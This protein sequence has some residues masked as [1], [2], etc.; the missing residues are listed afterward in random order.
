[1]QSC[2]VILLYYYFIARRSRSD[3][4]VVRFTF[5]NFHRL[6][7]DQS[8]FCSYRGHF[9]QCVFKNRKQWPRVIFLHGESCREPL[10]SLRW[11][12]IMVNQE[13]QCLSLCKNN[14]KG[15]AASQSSLSIWIN[16]CCVITLRKV[17]LWYGDPDSE[18]CSRGVKAGTT[19]KAE[20]Y[21][22]GRRPCW[23][24]QRPPRWLR[25]THQS[26]RFSWQQKGGGE[27]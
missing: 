24:A 1:M 13:Q 16:L 6:I 20:P 5:V 11:S 14:T 27:R 18:V 12:S 3:N 4:M 25:T 22:E 17:E 8:R 7:I 9:Q 26:D 21:Q 10:H 2:A 15:H 23:K 19:S